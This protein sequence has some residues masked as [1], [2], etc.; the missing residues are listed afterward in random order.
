MVY[1]EAQTMMRAEPEC[2]DAQARS[3]D[4]VL[5]NIITYIG[6]LWKFYHYNF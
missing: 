4:S 5:P 1:P 3:Q 6:D 2:G